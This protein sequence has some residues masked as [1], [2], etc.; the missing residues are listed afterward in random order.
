MPSVC[1]S[2]SY[3]SGPL[4]LKTSEDKGWHGVLFCSFPLL[5]LGGIFAEVSKDLIWIF[6]SISPL[7]HSF[8]ASQTCRVQ[9]TCCSSQGVCWQGRG[10]RYDFRGRVS[11][12][13]QR[14]HWQQAWQL[15]REISRIISPPPPPEVPP[16]PG[17]FK[18]R[19]VANTRA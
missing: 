2:L 5:V 10:D 11:A 9:Q 18:A 13:G 17:D 6:L 14:M 1:L 19:D 8:A 4:L 15:G 16:D 7:C 3:R 12:S